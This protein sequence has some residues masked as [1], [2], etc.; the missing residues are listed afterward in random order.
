MERWTYPVRRERF[1]FLRWFDGTVVSGFEGVAKPDA[2]VFELLLA[3]FGLE[4]SK[5]LFVDDSRTNVEAAHAVGMQAIQ[6]ESPAQL[7]EW[8]RGAGLLDGA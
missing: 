2:R 3:R 5:T 1:P 7:R 8:L 6:F 4:A